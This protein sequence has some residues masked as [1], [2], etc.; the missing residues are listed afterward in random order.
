[1][2]FEKESFRNLFERHSFHPAT[3]S[4]SLPS[5]IYLLCCWYLWPRGKNEERKIKSDE[6]RTLKLVVHYCCWMAPGTEREREKERERKIERERER[7]REKKRKRERQRDR[8]RERR[9]SGTVVAVA[10]KERQ[11]ECHRHISFS[12]SNLFPYTYSEQSGP[13]G[14][15]QTNG[16]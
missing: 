16:S 11:W 2:G 8:K 9:A 6:A 7:E 14:I 4:L 3:A 15:H 13:G 12:Y 1:M 5:E 10:R